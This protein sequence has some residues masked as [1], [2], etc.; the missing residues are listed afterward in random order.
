MNLRSFLSKL[1]KDG[2]LVRIK[3]S[4]SVKYEIAN[5]IYSLNEQP[6]FFENVTGYSFPV[7]AGITSNRDIIAEGLGTTKD[8]LLFKL[9]D[10]LHSPKSPE[11]V[12]KAPCQE[13]V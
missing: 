6:V 11:I 13:V 8:K 3:K 9:V 10:A 2:K 7:F 5:V 1:E 12:D 4:V